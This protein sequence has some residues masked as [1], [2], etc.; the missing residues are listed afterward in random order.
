MT[1]I[2]SMRSRVYSELMRKY[3]KQWLWQQARAVEQTSVYARGKAHDARRRRW[4]CL[5]QWI[6]WT[7][8][9]LTRQ[10]K[11]RHAEKVTLPNLARYCLK[12][13]RAVTQ[14]S[15]YFNVT[16]YQK[17]Q[18]QWK[19]SIQR[20]YLHI[21]TENTEEEQEQ[22]E[23]IEQ[24][25]EEVHVP[26]AMKRALRLWNE[27]VQLKAEHRQRL[28][29][30]EA[31]AVQKDAC[32]VLRE[33][34]Q[35]ICVQHHA[36]IQAYDRGRQ[37]H[38]GRR[39]VQGIR[40]W[41][42]YVATRIALRHTMD[43]ARRH[44]REERQYRPALTRWG[45]MT[46][47]WQ[48]Q[49]LASKR[50]R[51]YRQAQGWTAWTQRLGRL[52]A[53]HQRVR[54][55]RT[56]V[57]DYRRRRHLSRGVTRLQRLVHHRKQRTLVRDFRRRQ[58]IRRTFVHGFKVIWQQYNDAHAHEMQRARD[59][60]LRRQQRRRLW[61]WVTWKRQRRSQ[62]QLV[63][64]HHRRRCY[65]QTWTVQ[66][67]QSFHEQLKRPQ[68]QAMARA[69]QL[70]LVLAF[71]RSWR[72]WRRFVQRRVRFLQVALSKLLVRDV[73]GGTW[74]TA[75]EAEAWQR[76]RSAQL[77]DRVEQ[78]N[79]I[80][81]GGAMAS[82]RAR[83]N[84]NTSTGSSIATAATVTGMALLP[85]VG[86][87][88]LK[89]T[90]SSS[91]SM[92]MVPAVNAGVATLT[93]QWMK[94]R[95]LSSSRQVLRYL[96]QRRLVRR[97]M[98]HQ[99]HRTYHEAIVKPQRHAQHHAQRHQ[100]HVQ[101]FATFRQWRTLLE[102]LAT[103]RRLVRLAIVHEEQ[104]QQQVRLQRWVQQAV[105]H[106]QERRLA[107]EQYRLA[108]YRVGDAHRWAFHHRYVPVHELRRTQHRLWAHWTRYR[109]EVRLQRQATTLV[110]P[111]FHQL[112][113]VQERCLPRWRLYARLSH[114]FHR[115]RKQLVT[116]RLWCNWQ[117]I[118]AR[119]RT[120]RRILQWMM[121]RQKYQNLRRL[122][123]W[124]AFAQASLA[125]KY[126]HGV[127]PRHHHPNATDALPS[128]PTPTTPT[129]AT[130]AAVPPSSVG[131][132]RATVARA[133]GARVQARRQQT[134]QQQQLDT[135]HRHVQLY[136]AMHTYWLQD[137]VR[138]HQRMRK[139]DLVLNRY[140]LFLS[141]KR[142]MRLWDVH[143]HV[144]PFLTETRY[145]TADRAC[146]VQRMARGFRTLRWYLMERRA[147]KR[148]RLQQPRRVVAKESGQ[149]LAML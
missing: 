53:H 121:A 51:R 128:S 54:T 1:L 70:S 90:S 15:L 92:M 81:G 138:R 29:A 99:W 36:A 68:K 38:L 22:E 107:R 73:Y 91:S 33:W 126:A 30:G 100:Q 122:W 115:V 52:R 89:R 134:R 6:T 66:W 108:Q 110:A 143:T 140:Q 105:R 20:R 139:N 85:T 10:A 82:A 61:Q 56:R 129:K 112:F 65:Q 25:H 41:R 11:F 117:R 127:L 109:D 124:F 103:H 113:H 116:R 44:H 149:P 131:V 95:H 83:A 142:A 40:E 28:R 19:T 8:G 63:L 146:R 101:Y 45:T 84:S 132:A 123:R 133:H 48:R 59:M 35:R 74:L 102:T 9:R 23:H 31:L 16:Q 145:R 21:W 64:A 17:G 120:M 119:H 34:Q 43:L 5:Q 69:K 135:Y 75:E 144:R 32:L 46:H 76:Q 137:L 49:R 39:L 136:R 93:R 80:P 96:Q 94:T 4:A 79:R 87:R 13:W 104:R 125:K 55:N 60:F 118:H 42:E 58:L 12:E 26:L 2:R 67:R 62:R 98:M 148:Q 114:A 27:Y 86:A 106:G 141:L 57:T 7:Q 111:Q 37:H 3:L 24:F 72:R 88:P 50:T 71:R 14:E 47:A 18:L 78:T 130:V 97:A 147:Q 77:R